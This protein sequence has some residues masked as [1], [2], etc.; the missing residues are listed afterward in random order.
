MQVT[1]V[2]ILYESRDIEKKF[3]AARKAEKKQS[4]SVCVCARAKGAKNQ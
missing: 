2:I 4:V 1:R 3:I